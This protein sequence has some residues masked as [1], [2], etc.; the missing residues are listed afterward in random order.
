MAQTRR[1]MP[2]KPFLL[3]A[4]ADLVGCVTYC[5]AHQSIRSRGRNRQAVSTLPTFSPRCIR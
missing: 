5:L 2:I 3:T 4:I 1:V